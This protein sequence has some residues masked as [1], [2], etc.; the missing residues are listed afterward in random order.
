MYS[1]AV[2]LVLVFVCRAFGNRS[3]Y[4]YYAKF[5]MVYYAVIMGVALLF[6]VFLLR[7]KDPAN[8]KY[9]ILNIK[10]K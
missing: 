9:M 8:M 7:P 5:I 6:P 10:L 2:F 4:T 3:K 1:L